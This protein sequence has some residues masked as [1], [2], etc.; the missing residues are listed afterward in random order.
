M[1]PS[2]AAPAVP[3]RLRHHPTKIITKRKVPNL[4]RSRS[5]AMCY[6]ELLKCRDAA[7]DGCEE[8]AGFWPVLHIHAGEQRVG[9]AYH[10][11]MAWNRISAC[12]FS[13]GPE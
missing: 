6:G 2:C 7:I 11:R 1:L 4:S 8:P 5:S 3:P 9:A 10:D 13:A 12:Y